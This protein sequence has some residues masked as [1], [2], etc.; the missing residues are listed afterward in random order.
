MSKT[1]AILHSPFSPQMMDEEHHR[2][3]LLQIILNDIFQMHNAHASK[4]FECLCSSAPTFFP[5]DW[6]YPI[7]PLQKTQEHMLLLQQAFPTAKRKIQEFE[8]VLKKTLNLL[9]STKKKMVSC[10][11]IPLLRKLFYSI[12]PFIANCKE[13]E[14]LIYF[15]LKNR[16]QIE[17]PQIKALIAELD[18][19]HDC[20]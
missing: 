10:H 9:G 2:S 13:D 20:S 5:F 15:L 6:T 18:E 19:S 4:N 12:E 1:A 8:K 14:N 11:L 3:L 16:L 7:C 17:I